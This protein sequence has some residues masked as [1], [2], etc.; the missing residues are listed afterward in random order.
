MNSEFSR[1]DFLGKLIFKGLGRVLVSHGLQAP[2]ALL[3]A[4]PNRMLVQ[5]PAAQGVAGGELQVKGRPSQQGAR[6]HQTV[7]RQ[8]KAMQ[9]DSQG[10]GHCGQGR[11][12]TI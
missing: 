2:Q 3:M 9:M 11:K 8:L 12:G 6:L 1:A 4:Q 10:Q 5:H 7:Q